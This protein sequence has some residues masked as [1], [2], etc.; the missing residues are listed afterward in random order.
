MA[1]GS[2]KAQT[3]RAIFKEYKI[4]FQGMH[5]SEILADIPN[6]WGKPG[7]RDLIAILLC[8]ITGNHRE[9]HLCSSSCFGTFEL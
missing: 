2:E 7:Q 9:S 3:V 5:T 8:V 6:I 4:Y 1:K